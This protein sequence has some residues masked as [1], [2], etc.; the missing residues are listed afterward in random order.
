VAN[1]RDRDTRAYQ[2][3]PETNYPCFHNNKWTMAMSDFEFLY[4]LI[5]IVIGFGLTH[6]LAGLGRAF[7]FRA[8]SKLDAVH[9]AW[10]VTTFFILVLNWWVSLLWRD[11]GDWTF[12]VFFTMILWT[13]SMYVMAL[14]LYPPQLSGD[15]DYRSI[16]E[17]NRTWFLA[18]FTIMALLDLMVTA[19]REQS[20]PTPLYIY[21]VGHYAVITAVGIGVKNRRYDLFAAWYIAL[22][23]AL[24]SFGVRGTLS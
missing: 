12:T 5:S 18:T 16:F 3:F 20:I 15:V 21:F 22:T 13:T 11:F 14:A 19:L 4:V 23:L 9:I 17:A 6:L 7:H 2:Y 10:T 8:T 24:W 1:F